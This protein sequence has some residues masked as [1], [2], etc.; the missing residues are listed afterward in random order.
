MIAVD[1]TRADIYDTIGKEL[2]GLEVGTL[3][4]FWDAERKYLIKKDML[5]SNWLITLTMLTYLIEINRYR[6]Q[7]VQ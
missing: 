3:G 4:K 6:A 7:S 5:T 1:F 2:D